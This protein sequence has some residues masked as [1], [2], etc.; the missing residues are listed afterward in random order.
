[1]PQNSGPS[2]LLV[3]HIDLTNTSADDDGVRIKDIDHSSQGFREFLLQ[4][5]E[6]FLAQ[7][8]SF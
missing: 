7:G 6:C 2:L 8:I 1:M 4:S 3:K 5:F